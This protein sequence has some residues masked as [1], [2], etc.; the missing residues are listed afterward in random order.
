MNIKY[1]TER[2]FT[3][4][5]VQSLFCSVKWVSGNYPNRLLQALNNSSVVFTAWDGE[6]LVGLLRGLDDGCMTAYL[7]Y[8]LVHPDYQSMGIA[9]RLIDM[10][11][12]RYA[13]YL[14]IN[15]MPEESNN[16]PFYERHGFSIMPDGV[17]M[18]ITHAIDDK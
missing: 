8:M 3:K 11:K 6:R 14:Y 17:A 12:Q 15:V 2:H 1:T 18:Q 9:T 7:H 10:A 16:A 5:Q 4:E 13:D